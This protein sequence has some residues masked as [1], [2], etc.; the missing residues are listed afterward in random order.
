[1]FLKKRLIGFSYSNINKAKDKQTKKL[2]IYVPAEFVYMFINRINIKVTHVSGTLVVV[3]A[4]S[5]S[6]D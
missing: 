2:L 1:M 4:S 5:F 3:V 6:G